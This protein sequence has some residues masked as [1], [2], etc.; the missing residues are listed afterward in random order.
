MVFGKQSLQ[1]YESNRR[2]ADGVRVENIPRNH[3]VGPSRADSKINDRST[4]WTGAPPKTG[5]SSRQ[6]S[7]TL[8]GKQ[9]A[10]KNNVNAI[11]WQLRVMLANCLAVIGLSW[12]LTRRT[13]DRMAEDMMANFSGSGHPICRASSAFERGELRSKG[14]GKKPIPIKGSIET[15]ELLLRTVI[16]ADQLSIYGAI[17]H[18]CD[19]VPKVLGSGKTCSTWSFGKDGNSLLTSLLQKI[20][21]MHSNGEIWCKNTSENSNK[22]QKTRS[23]PNCFLMRGWTLSNE[24]STS[25][26]LKQK[27]DHRCNIYAE[28]TRCLAMRRGLV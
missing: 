8:N 5:S 2:N 4:V 26:L 24:N 23:Y 21:P 17:A 3:S 1:G 13:W 18:S 25:I 20:P 28:N 11:H 16:S 15:I 19:E 10:I 14:G 7:T 22:C 9:K 27:K 12:G 6:C